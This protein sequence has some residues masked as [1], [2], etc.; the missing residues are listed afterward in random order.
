MKKVLF[1]ATVQSH[2]TN[3]HLPYLRYF[4]EEGYEVHVA[5]KGNGDIAYCDVFHDIPFERSP[6]KK[7]NIKAYRQL[8]QV[9]K[10]NQ[11]EIIHCHTP[12]GAALTRMAAKKARESGTKVIY[13]AHG[14]HFFDG[15]PLLNWLVY[16]P[17]EWLLS[18]QTDTLITINQED[19]QRARK[20]LHAKKT[21]FVPGVGIDAKKFDNQMDRQ[22]MRHSLGLDD[23]TIALIFVGELNKNK[24]QGM[25]LQ[26]VEQLR[27]QSLPVVLLLAGTGDQEKTY[28]DMA[29]ERKI[30][31]S[32]QFL[33]WRE[34]IPALLQSADIYTSASQREGL[35]LNLVEAQ[36]AGLPVIA[37]DVRGQRDIVLEN[38]TG[39]LTP[40][41]AKKI[42]DKIAKL[43]NDVALR[44]YFAQNGKKRAQQYTL[45]AVFPQMKSIYE[46]VLTKEAD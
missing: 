32:I 23:N 40:I 35:P 12:M 25:L 36:L 31:D 29:R 20:H 10:E 8:K 34:D 1:S 18:F 33:G 7:N 6:F 2:I 38:K 42:V 27:M 45:A 15:A 22:E 21:K 30:Q 5:C 46:E 14:F 3:F 41:D 4:Q 44:E 13:T 16:Y 11:Y 17:I 19:Y 24:N 26:A 39:Y 9:I 37:T 43:I 28:Q